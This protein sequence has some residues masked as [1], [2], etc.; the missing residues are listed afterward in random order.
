MIMLFA[1]SSELV[2]V[3][4]GSVICNGESQSNHNR[5]SLVAAY[6]SPIDSR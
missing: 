4:G 2:R 6:G 5:I 3:Y 1:K